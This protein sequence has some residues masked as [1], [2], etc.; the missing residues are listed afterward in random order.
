V[1]CPPKPYEL[2]KRRARSKAAMPGF[3]DFELAE[4]SET[5]PDGLQWVHEVKF[6]G[7]RIQVHVEQGKVT[8]YTR[9]GHDWTIKFPLIAKAARALPDCIIDGEAVVLMEE[10]PA[11]FDALQSALGA[12]PTIT[13]KSNK[14]PRGHRVRSKVS[15]DC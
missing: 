5:T 8:V 13:A 12:T 3:I 7:Y 1:Q 10:G 4:L 14:R 11:S 9:R 2:P 15:A 6:D